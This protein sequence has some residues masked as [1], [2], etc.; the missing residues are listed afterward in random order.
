MST[1]VYVKVA[2][3]NRNA[4]RLADN[5]RRQAN[6][7]G[8]L[9]FRAMRGQTDEQFRRRGYHRLEF[10]TRAL[11]LRFEEFIEENCD[12]AV[13]TERYRVPPRTRR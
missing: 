2:K 6:Y 9:G 12:S 13:Y 8:P 1:A 10:P 4:V 11:A 7:L 5:A 3:T